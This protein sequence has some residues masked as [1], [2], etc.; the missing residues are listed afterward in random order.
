MAITSPPTLTNLSRVDKAFGCHLVKA[1]ENIG[2]DDSNLQSFFIRPSHHK[3]FRGE[4]DSPLVF[5]KQLGKQGYFQQ[6]NQTAAV[7]LPL[8]Y[9][10]RDISLASADPEH[11]GGIY[12]DI[13][14]L[15]DLETPYQ[16]QVMY[17]DITYRL[18]FVGHERNHPE[19]LALAWYF[20]I[21]QKQHN[22]HKIPLIYLI[23]DEKFTAEAYIR[24]PETLLATDISLDPHQEARLFALEVQHTLLTPILVGNEGQLIEPIQFNL[25]VFPFGSQPNI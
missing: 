10:F 14:W 9:Y 11:Y 17:F 1:Y 21:N 16:L 7:T 12:Q 3:I 22:H 2:S 20:F 6:Q 24:E 25:R 23:A 5:M 4:L 15:K 18:V 13:L 8:I 19:Q